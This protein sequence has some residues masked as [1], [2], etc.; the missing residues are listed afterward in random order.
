MSVHPTGEHRSVSH[1]TVPWCPV[2]PAPDTNSPT[3][4]CHRNLGKALCCGPWNLLQDF[5]PST[6]VLSLPK[7]GN[8][9]FWCPS[10][11]CLELREAA[12]LDS[13]HIPACPRPAS[14]PTGLLW[15]PSKVQLFSGSLS[16]HCA[17]P[18]ALQGTPRLSPFIGTSV[19]PLFLPPLSPL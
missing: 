16:P 19:L 6:W 8:Q 2:S 17:L 13:Q 7:V 14:H 10:H 9:E 11:W 18:A 1:S 4:C 15:F 5:F 3:M 12:C